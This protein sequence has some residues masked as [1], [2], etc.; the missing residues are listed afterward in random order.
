MLAICTLLSLALA[1][2]RFEIRRL[3]NYRIT[4]KNVWTPKARFT[5]KM[6]FVRQTIF[7]LSVL[8]LALF[9]LETN[10]KQLNHVYIF[11]FLTFTCAIGQ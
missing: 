7:K 5:L 3:R 11:L 9:E 6:A 2:G 8:R 1:S 10:T 4:E